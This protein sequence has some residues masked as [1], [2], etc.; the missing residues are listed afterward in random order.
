MKSVGGLA[1]GSVSSLA[2]GTGG[3]TAGAPW[4]PVYRHAQ[5]LSVWQEI[6]YPLYDHQSDSG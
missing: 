4:F 5:I 3:K 1:A 6:H 2:N